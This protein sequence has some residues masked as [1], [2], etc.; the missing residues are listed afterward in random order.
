M[1]P[2]P[3]TFNYLVGGYVVFSVV[4]LVYLVSLVSRWNNLRREQQVLEEIEKSA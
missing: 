1:E 2:T 4:M 3:D